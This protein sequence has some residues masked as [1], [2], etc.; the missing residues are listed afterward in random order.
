MTDSETPQEAFEKLGIDKVRLMVRNGNTPAKWGPD[1]LN[2]VADYD[3]RERERIE[4]SNSSQ[5]RTALSANRAAWIAAIA[6]TIAA[7]LT[8]ISIVISVLAWVYPNGA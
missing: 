4:A 2:W 5:A 6:A 1:A 3:R 7:A 8:I